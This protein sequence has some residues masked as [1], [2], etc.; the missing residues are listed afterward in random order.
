M[1]L[2]FLYFENLQRT[3]HRYILTAPTQAKALISLIKFNLLDKK[4]SEEKKKEKD[5]GRKTKYII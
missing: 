2:S 4:M 1:L 5:E 3:L